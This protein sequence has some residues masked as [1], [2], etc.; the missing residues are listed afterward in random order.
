MSFNTAH[1]VRVNSIAVRLGSAI[2]RLRLQLGLSQMELANRANIN[3]TILSAMESGQRLPT[4]RTVN[5][6]ARGL[7]VPVWE[8]LL[9]AE[10]EYKKPF[11][12]EIETRGLFRVRKNK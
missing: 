3:Y 2:K 10:P 5:K 4:L 12:D 9:M 6:V 11:L 1:E 7:K 8:L